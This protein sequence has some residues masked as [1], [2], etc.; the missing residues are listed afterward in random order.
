MKR[1]ISIILLVFMLCN[2]FA[3][4]CCAEAG[5]QPRA[6][7]YFSSYGVNLSRQSDGRIKIV[8]SAAGTDTCS[9]LGVASYQIEEKNSSGNWEDFTGLLSGQ[10]GS[11]VATYSFSRYFT[12][13][14]GNSY[15]VKCVFTCTLNGTSE[16]KNYTSGT[17][18]A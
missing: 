18:K 7:A 13:V 2:M 11:G 9:Q 14:C 4:G 10:T 16:H 15:R 1:T 12:P 17:I 5:V 6:S 8:F 3:L